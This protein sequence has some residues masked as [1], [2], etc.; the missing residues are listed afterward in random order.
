MTLASSLFG[1]GFETTTNLIGNGLF[2][3]L[4]HPDEMVRLRREPSLLANLS[5]ELLRY[6]STAQLTSRFTKAGVEV[7][8]TPIPKGEPVMIVLGAANHDP[9]RY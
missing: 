4:E 9:A 5:D 7:A 3:L 2:A 1:A 8:G 6:D